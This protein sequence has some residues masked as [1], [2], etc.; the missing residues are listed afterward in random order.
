MKRKAKYVEK[1]T[2][3]E[4][5]PEEATPVDVAVV[6]PVV[7]TKVTQEPVLKIE[8]VARGFRQYRPHHLQ[9]IVSFCN[10]RGFLLQGT[11][12]Q[13]LNTLAQFGW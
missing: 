6:L 13:L 11:K 4:P 7:E 9:A 12:A 10:S 8:E 5:T 1:N 3:P 2:T